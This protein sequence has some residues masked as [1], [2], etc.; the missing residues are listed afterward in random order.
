MSVT[1]RFQID[2]RYYAKSDGRWWLSADGIEWSSQIS[3]PASTPPEFNTEGSNFQVFEDDGEMWAIVDS[4]NGR[5][6]LLHKEGADWVE[7]SVTLPRPPPGVEFVNT[8]QGAITVPHARRYR[9]A[10]VPPTGPS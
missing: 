1:T 7:A 6:R 10:S 2:R 5:L 4:I 8:D 9:Y 3:P